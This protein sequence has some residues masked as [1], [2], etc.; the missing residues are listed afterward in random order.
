MCKSTTQLK[1]G[2]LV[3]SHGYL[4]WN[5]ENNPTLISWDTK[6]GGPPFCGCSC[7]WNN[8]SWLC[9]ACDTG[10]LVCFGISQGQ[11]PSEIPMQITQ[12]GMYLASFT[13]IVSHFSVDDAVFFLIPPP[14]LSHPY[15][16]GEERL[17]LHKM[18]CCPSIFCWQK[19]EIPMLFPSLE[20][21]KLYELIWEIPVPE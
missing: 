9:T 2:Y 11:W 19:S 1:K 14:L 17:I 13:C 5:K 8:I 6:R 7:N 15:F 10:N 3:S 16:C 4:W 18:V 12:S 20:G 21:L